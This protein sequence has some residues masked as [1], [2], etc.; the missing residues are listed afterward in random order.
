[1]H[2]F[3]SS[4]LTRANVTGPAGVRPCKAPYVFSTPSVLP[5]MGAVPMLMSGRKLFAQLPQWN[6]IYLQADLAAD[7]NGKIQPYRNAG[8]ARIRGVEL[9]S[10]GQILP[11]LQLRG[12]YTYNNAQ[13]TDNPAIPNSVGKRVTYVPRH[14]A[15][16]MLLAARTK[17]SASLSGRY[18][19]HCFGTDLNT[20]VVTGVPG[21]FDPYF[22]ISGTVAYSVTR[23]V[24]VN[25]NGDNL[26]D[27]NYFQSSYLAPA[28]AVYL[29][30]RLRL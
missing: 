21:S 12:T 30:L 5:R 22:M 16:G 17:W 24:S 23:H 11:W 4:V 3:R 29:G 13:I 1:M 27:R 18:V 9:S 20:D 28:R 14:Q 7:P 8:Y 10:K 2:P 19:G 6:L 15:P 25:V 26:L